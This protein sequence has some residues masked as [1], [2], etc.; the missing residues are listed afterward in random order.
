MLGRGRDDN[1]GGRRA[2]RGS[3]HRD[4]KR[5]RRGVYYILCT[6]SREQYYTMQ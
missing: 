6:I 5:G 3:A 2:K 1:V 4:M